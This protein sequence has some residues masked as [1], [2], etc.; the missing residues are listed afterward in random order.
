MLTIIR[1]KFNVKYSFYSKKPEEPKPNFKNKNAIS[2]N[3]DYLEESIARSKRTVM[4]YG[5]NNNWDYFFTL[6]L[7]DKQLRYDFDLAKQKLLSLFVGL[8]RKD[9]S[10]RY[11][12]IPELTK[13]GAIHFHCLIK[14]TPGLIKLDYLYFDKKT[15]N[16]I[17]YSKAINN[18]FGRNNFIPINNDTPY[19][20]Y[21]VSKYISKDCQRLFKC[22]YFASKGLNKSQRTVV[23]NN[24]T[25]QHF[26]YLLNRSEISSYHN[27]F[28][29]SFTMENGN[30]W[31][32]HLTNLV[33][34]DIIK[35]VKE[36]DDNEK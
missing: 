34:R 14:M 10:F 9:T 22:S 19:V 26:I 23:S 16:R 31:D 25:I 5:L 1:N 2:S 3:R 35:V 6:T 7:A 12:C 8:K 27:D 17:Y 15:H 11:L 18:K 20:V 21:Y 24:Y 13:K 33:N 36:N 30:F 32:L 28:V 4:E 29:T